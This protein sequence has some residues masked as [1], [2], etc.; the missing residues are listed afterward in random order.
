MSQGERR[1]S[2]TPARK[3]FQMWAQFR[4]NPLTERY[5]RRRNRFAAPRSQDARRGLRAVPWPVGLWG[6]APA[7][8]GGRELRRDGHERATAVHEL[9]AGALCLRS[10]R[11]APAQNG[12]QWAATRAMRAVLRAWCMLRSPAASVL[13]SGLAIRVTMRSSSLKSYRALTVLSTLLGLHWS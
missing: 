7:G 5:K 9:R 12:A 10:H 4:S 2:G 11:T 3:R 13:R 1:R 8:W 6:A